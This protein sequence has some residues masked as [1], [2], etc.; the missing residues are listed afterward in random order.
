MELTIKQITTK[1]WRLYKS[2]RLET[3]EMEPKAFSSKYVITI[4]YADSFWKELLDNNDNKFFVASYKKKA[5]GVIRV[6]YNDIDEPEKTA[7]LGGLY[8]N[9]AY[10]GK[11]IGKALM[12]RAIERIEKDKNTTHI[13][14]Y[15]KPS[16]DEAIKLYE[17]LD[18]KKVSG[19]SGE[20]VFKKS[21]NKSSQHRS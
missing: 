16:Q 5:V 20:Y 17:K 4:N 14:L 3:L 7:I 6:T 19:K 13:T 8:V 18:F 11:G 2:I 10:R 1:D 12:L 21:A 9:E 15:V